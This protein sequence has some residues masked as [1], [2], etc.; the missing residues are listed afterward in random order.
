[1][2]ASSSNSSSTGSH[3]DRDQFEEG[4]GSV[5]WWGFSPASAVWNNNGGG[6]GDDDLEVL[7]LGAGDGRH[8]VHAMAAE[9]DVPVVEANKLH[10]HVYEQNVMLYA[11][12]ILFIR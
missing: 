8:I 4:L 9:E 5:T 1:M 10:F 7:L 12:Q 3:L 11:R 2:S 6:N